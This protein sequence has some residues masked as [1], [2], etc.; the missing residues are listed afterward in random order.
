[1]AHDDVVDGRVVDDREVD[2]FVTSFSATGSL[3]DLRVIDV[4]PSKPV[5][6]LGDGTTFLGR[7]S[8]S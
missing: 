4:V 5:S 7:R 6:G 3:I 8:S 1:M 2:D